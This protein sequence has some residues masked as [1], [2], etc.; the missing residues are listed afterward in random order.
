M[1]D[2]PSFR[3]FAGAVLSNDMAK[4][5]ATLSALLDLDSSAARAATE[6]F[7]L[8]MSTGPAFMM[9]AMG[10]REVVQSGDQN[11]LRTLLSELF[12]LSKEVQETAIVAI[13]TRYRS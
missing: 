1:S 5:S 4:A 13:R 12:G 7:Q 3:D 8:Q 9:K 11:K 2:E 6:H 10:M